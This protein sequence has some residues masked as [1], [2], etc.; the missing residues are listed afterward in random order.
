[1]INEDYSEFSLL[2]FYFK[3]KFL[4]DSYTH[5]YKSTIGE[6]RRVKL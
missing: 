1:M 3:K 2:L 5:F 4:C 6:T